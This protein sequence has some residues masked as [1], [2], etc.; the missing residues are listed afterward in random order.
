MSMRGT[1]TIHVTACY[2][3]GL[4]FDRNEAYGALDHN[5]QRACTSQL[6]AS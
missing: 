3:C 4:P 2:F 1:G 5:Q 6:R